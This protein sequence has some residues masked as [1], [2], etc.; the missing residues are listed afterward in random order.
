MAERAA[1]VDP[2]QDG[3]SARPAFVDPYAAPAERSATPAEQPRSWSDV[4]LEAVKNI[5]SD[6]YNTIADIIGTGASV[7][8]TVAP[9]LAKHGPLALNAMAAD[10][11]KAIYNDPSLLKKIPAAVWND[12]VDSYG[13]EDAIKKT[14]ATHPVK[15]GLDLAT[16]LGGVEAGVGRATRGI[17]AI[18]EAA[19]VSKPFFEGLPREAPPVEP[20][21]P[22]S[23]PA[24][25][26]P[27]P[28]QAAIESQPRAL[29]TD[30]RLLQ[31][32]GQ[33]IAKTP[34][35]GAVGRA[36][37]AV[38][39]KFGEARN[40]VADELGSYRT[41]QNIAGD[42]RAEIGG[43]AEAETAAR[44]AEAQ[45]IDAAN[46]AA[47][48]QANQAREAAIAQQEARST[49]AA[50]AQLGNVAP[51]NMGDAVIDT[52]R[53]SHDAARNAKD[54]A[55]RDAAGI[56]ASVLDQA[57]ADALASVQQSLRSDIGGQGTVDV[58][59]AAAKT[60]RGM[61][62]R[63]RQFSSQAAERRAAAVS[64]A[65]AETGLPPNQITPAIRAQAEANAAQ[66]GQSMRDIERV[67]QDLNFAA[68]GADNDADRR[69]ARRIIQGF[70]QWHENAMERA[71]MEGSDPSALEAYRNARNLN[72]D[73]RER[74]GYND[75]NDAD[76]I[77]NKI[78]QPGNQIGPEDISKALFAGGNKPNR[79]LD[80]IFQAT[81]DHPNHN[82]VV[83]AIRGGIWNDIA[84]I[85][86]GEKART[87][88]NIADSIHSF[89]NRRDMADRLFTPQ[90]QALA[91]R[92]AE[93]LRAAVRARDESAALAKANKPV[94]TEVTKGPMQDLADRVLGRGQKSDE[95]LFDAI[96]GYAKS[97]GGG[98]DIATLAHVMR[99]I[100]DQLKGNFR[101]TFIRRLGRGQKDEFSPAIFAKEWTQNVNPEAKAVL[102]GD[103]AHVR[104]LDDLAAASKTY[105]EVHRRFGNPSGSGHTVNFGHLAALVAGMA[106]GSILGPLKILGGWFAAN[107]L[108]N[109]LASPAG[110]ASASRFA[111]Q[112]RRLQSAPTLANAAAARMTVRN[113]RN[114]ATAL[115]IAHT[116]PNDK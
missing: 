74:F 108:S 78:V 109:F 6:A 2:F 7:A 116:I 90:E 87:A 97:K 44:Q 53:A 68:S 102:F 83:Q 63:I 33:V 113:M 85:G 12:L 91:R 49:Q 31:Q 34:F 70:D 24:L 13:S 59:A 26:P 51:V 37:E 54:A 45:R 67:R 36:V 77:L 17:R 23:P 99:S 62:G 64:D 3:G 18:S 30:S 32:T 92:H 48:E 86:A 8:K 28:V 73:F 47:Y 20:P 41:P 57:N 29:T 35:G 82:N 115:G 38:P 15:F 110:A 71:L 105:D 4:P 56:D 114:T 55:Y 42:I 100:P 93:T 106:A 76:A 89:M 75:R 79:L 69:A 1:F 96:E 94:P 80:A 22:A 16:V 39:G 58:R 103:G 95:A 72:H 111:V 5:P 40:A 112:M 19:D 65:L 101:N 60:A 88:E 66:T 25:P 50:Q 84:G 46:Q 14:I 104:A 43:Q 27:G 10:A 61:L 98:K 21:P 52:V 107:K 81:G 9:Y 11:T